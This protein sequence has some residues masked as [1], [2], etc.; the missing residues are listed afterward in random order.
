MTMTFGKHAIAAAL[1]AVVLAAPAAAQNRPNSADAPVMWGADTVTYRPDGVTL[2]GRAELLQG[3]NRM[4]ANR[5]SLSTDAGGDLTRIEATGDVYYVTP[6]QT[7]R[8]DSAVYTPSNDTVTITG[9]VILTQGE[10][11]MTGG[12]LT[13]NLRT[14]QAQMAGGANGRV[15]GVFY[16]QRSGRQ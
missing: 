6:T 2:D 10:N 11:V 5:L 12:R 16:P 3:D 15:Q 1:A 14:E 9:D 7:M 8:G 13:Y 4:R